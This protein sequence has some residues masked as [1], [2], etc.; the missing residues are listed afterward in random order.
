MCLPVFAPDEQEVGF[1]GKDGVDRAFQPDELSEELVPFFDNRLHL[2][3]KPTGVFGELQNDL[4]G[5]DRKW[6]DLPGSL[7]A[8]KGLYN[9]LLSEQHTAA[10]P[11]STKRLGKGA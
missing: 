10:H 6:S 9:W 11:S 1:R 8:H 4:G 2:L 3:L 5:L 7:Q